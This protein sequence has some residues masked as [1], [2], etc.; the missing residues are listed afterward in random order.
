M[1]FSQLIA[2]AEQS[3]EKILLWARNIGPMT[4]TLCERIMG[5]RVHP[6]Q[7]YRSCM[8]IARL[9]KRFGKARVEAAAT[10]ALATGAVSYRSVANILEAGLDR[11]PVHDDRDAAPAPVSHHD[12]IRGPKHY[13]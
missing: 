11:E 1:N 7:G 5:Q 3:P 12:N 4:Q 6:E 8:G 13:H 10:R 9:G 2:Q